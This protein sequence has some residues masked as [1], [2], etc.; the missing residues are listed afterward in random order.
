ML[1]EKPDI[2]HRRNLDTES[3][4]PSCRNSPR[5]RTILKIL[6][7]SGGYQF[8]QI[9]PGIKSLYDRVENLFIHWPGR[10]NL[11]SGRQFQQIYR[12]L[13]PPGHISP[14][15]LD[16]VCMC[17]FNRDF[18]SLANLYETTIHK[19]ASLKKETENPF[20]VSIKSLLRFY[21]ACYSFAFMFLYLEFNS[22]YKV[23][24]LILII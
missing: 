7:F 6:Y 4:G 5:L 11:G 18:F 9:L 21:D 19:S 13:K 10:H 2:T 12:P 24:H 3:L 22:F 20:N 23:D 16:R 8:F 14:G 17:L 1:L 15:H